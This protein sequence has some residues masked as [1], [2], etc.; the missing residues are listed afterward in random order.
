VVEPEGEGEGAGKSVGTAVGPA[1]LAV[2]VAVGLVVGA[3]VASLGNMLGCGEEAGVGKVL[4]GRTE[5]VEDG[6]RVGDGVGFVVIGEMGAATGA[7]V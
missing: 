3:G 5:G 6:S 4:V 1:G 7:G 2:G